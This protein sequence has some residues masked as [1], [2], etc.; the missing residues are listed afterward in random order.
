LEGVSELFVRGVEFEDDRRAS[1]T[2]ELNGH[3]QAAKMMTG[4]QSENTPS[5]Q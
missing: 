2:R 5:P 4:E 1:G 3:A